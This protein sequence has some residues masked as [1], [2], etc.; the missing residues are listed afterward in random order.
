[1]VQIVSKHRI[2]THHRTAQDLAP[3]HMWFKLS[4]STKSA[5]TAGPPNYPKPVHYMFNIYVGPKNFWTGQEQSRVVLWIAVAVSSSDFLDIRK[6]VLYKLFGVYPSE[7]LFEG[8]SSNDTTASRETPLTTSQHQTNLEHCQIER[9]NHVI[10]TLQYQ[11]IPQPVPE[12]NLLFLSVLRVKILSWMWIQMVE[13]FPH[14][15]Q[16]GAMVSLC[17]WIKALLYSVPH[18]KQKQAVVPTK[19]RNLKLYRQALGS[20]LQ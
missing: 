8:D 18:N 15:S 7:H 16:Q 3:N 9:D 14:H 6:S 4:A 19:G 1:M 11:H 12:I 20:S 2:S 17:Q 5:P 13:L 10:T